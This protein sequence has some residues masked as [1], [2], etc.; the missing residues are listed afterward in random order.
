MGGERYPGGGILGL[1]FG[2]GA[3]A[4]DGFVQADCHGLSGS[5][6]GEH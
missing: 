6:D 2:A 4:P 3:G 1:V 5:R